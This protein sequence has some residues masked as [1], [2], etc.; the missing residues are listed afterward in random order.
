MPIPNDVLE[1]KSA[2][3]ARL[4]S[5]GAERRVI[6]RFRTLSVMA[7]AASAGNNVHAVGVGHKI[8][9]GR[10]TDQPAVRL[11]VVQKL[12]ESLLSNEDVLPTEIDGSPT[13]V[14]E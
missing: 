11:Y 3:S 13:E 12:A 5:V 8:V 6:G 7:A 9:D 2:I 1:A 10:L 14:I 4:L